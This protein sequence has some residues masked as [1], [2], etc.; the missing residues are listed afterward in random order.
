MG[1]RYINKRCGRPYRQF[2]SK[3]Y[4]KEVQDIFQSMGWVLSRS[5]SYSD[6]CINLRRLGI[7]TYALQKKIK[8]LSHQHRKEHALHDT[9]SMYW[10]RTWQTPNYR[11]YAQRSF[12]EPLCIAKIY[13]NLRPRPCFEFPKIPTILEQYHTKIANF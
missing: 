10:E 13:G 12:Q 3:N 9:T 7:P 11:T 2:M 1:K 4:K 8:L 5:Q 6:K